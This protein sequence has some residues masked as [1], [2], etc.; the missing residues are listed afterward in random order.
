[1]KFSEFEGKITKITDYS[2]DGKS[3]AKVFNVDIDG[4]KLD[5]LPGQF[6]MIS[7]GNVPS[8]I[9]PS[10]LK[11]SSMSICSAPHQKGLIELCIRMPDHPGVSKYLKEH[12]K[13]GEKIKF[14]GP[15]GTFRMVEEQSAVVF[16]ATGTGIAPLMSMLRHLLHKNFSGKI[17]FF[18]GCRSNDDFLYKKELMECQ[19]KHE[20]FELHASFS[21]AMLE[22]RM[23]Y[24]QEIVKNH[25]FPEDK[26]GIHA[27]VCGNPVSVQQQTETLKD[28]GFEEKSLHFE[29]W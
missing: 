20:N 25:V 22:G 13:T 1:M 15:F 26:A 5:F 8:P 12:A 7:A 17:W 28:K 2:H 18:Y 23:G 27:Y 21:K 11:Y 6:V 10:R 16:V 14:K 9:D 24:I 4:V 3:V 29:K 19:K